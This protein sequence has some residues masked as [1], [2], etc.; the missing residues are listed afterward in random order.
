M[1][2]SVDATAAARQPVS[3]AV[4]RRAIKANDNDDDDERSREAAACSRAVRAAVVGGFFRAIA[5][6]VTWLVRVCAPV[7][8]RLSRR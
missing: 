8:I 3:P 2:P 4:E 1:G 6:R 5:A 7:T